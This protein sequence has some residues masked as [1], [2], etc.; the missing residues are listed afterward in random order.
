MILFDWPLVATMALFYLISWVYGW[1][2]LHFFRYEFHWDKAAVMGIASVTS[3][4]FLIVWTVRLYILGY[5]EPSLATVTQFV[6]DLMWVFFAALPGMM[7]V[8]EVLVSDQQEMKA[9]LKQLREWKQRI[10]SM[11]K[12]DQPTA[13]I[14]KNANNEAT[15]TINHLEPAVHRET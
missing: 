4:T 8:R 2:L 5:S 12:S 1:G 3:I 9:E 6:W 11:P 7:K 13:E 14:K 10:D 15:L